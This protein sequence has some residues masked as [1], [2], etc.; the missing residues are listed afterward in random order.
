MAIYDI[1]NAEKKDNKFEEEL[2]AEVSLP[3]MEP[4]I[5]QAPV[6]EPCSLKDR[7]LSSLCAR[8]FFFVLFLFDVLWFAFST[9]RIAI[10]ALLHLL[11]FCRMSLFKDKSIKAWLSIKRSIICGLSLI[12]A[13]FNPAFGIMI[14]CT[15]FL[16]YDK[17]GIEE[18]V[19][20]SLKEQFKDLF[21]Q[22]SHKE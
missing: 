9:V 11:C 7:V 12:V 14:A 19:P 10:F 6:S 3:E 8:L 5:E 4:R 17:K 20:S 15:Y 22:A 2:L 16:M 13:L 1:F 21:S 18:V